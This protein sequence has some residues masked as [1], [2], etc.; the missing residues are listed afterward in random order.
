M[1]YTLIHYIYPQTHILPLYIEKNEK[2]YIE[3]KVFL[4]N[5]DN[6]VLNIDNKM[7]LNIDIKNRMNRFAFFDSIFN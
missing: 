5:K 1:L 3:K 2:K 7:L 6:L 4:E